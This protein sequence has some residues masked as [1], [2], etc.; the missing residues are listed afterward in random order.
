MGN[1]TLILKNVWRPSANINSFFNS[2][3]FFFR[4][5]I[6]I[7]ESSL[8]S[9]HFFKPHAGDEAISLSTQELKRPVINSNVWK[10]IK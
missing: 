5:K 3:L 6:L 10:Y 1:N 2:H 8:I 7:Q 9:K 4:E